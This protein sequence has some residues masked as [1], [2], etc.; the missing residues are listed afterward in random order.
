M[1][2]TVVV[3]VDGSAPSIAALRFAAEEA[4]RRNA[5]LVAVHAWTFVAA[6]AVADPGLIPVPDVDY[7]GQLEAE[8]NAAQAEIDTALEKAFPNGLPVD[9]DARLVEAPAGEALLAEGE[10]ADL[11]VVGS[12]G[13]SGLTSVLLGSVSRHV[14]SHSH[15]P[16]TVVKATDPD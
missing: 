2:G 9:V 16:V 3:G 11:I 7:V 15:S 1:P 12:S 14:V 10:N 5:Q 8:R 4:E 6:S 13:K